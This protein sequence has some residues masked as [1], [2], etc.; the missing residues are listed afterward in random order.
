MDQD[1]LDFID[2]EDRYLMDQ[3]NRV[4]AKLYYNEIPQLAPSVAKKIVDQE[5]A[6]IMEPVLLEMIQQKMVDGVIDEIEYMVLEDPLNKTNAH[7]ALWKQ[8][9]TW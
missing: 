4:F 9:D 6:K 1:G 7:V 3:Q 5:K 8:L 2:T